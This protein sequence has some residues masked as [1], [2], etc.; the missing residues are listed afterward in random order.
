MFWA[1]FLQFLCHMPLINTKFLSI[2]FVSL[3]HCDKKKFSL[4]LWITAT[5]KKMFVALSHCDKKNLYMLHKICQKCQQ[6]STFWHCWPLFGTFWDFM[7]YI[8]FVEDFVVVFWNFLV[9]YT[10]FVCR[11]D[12]LRQ[13]K[14]LFVAAAQC[15]KP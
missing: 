15:H 10:D 12:S 2:S 14:I 1:F 6:C 11:S 8:A 4:L 13:T 3:S 9:T 7:P 5:I